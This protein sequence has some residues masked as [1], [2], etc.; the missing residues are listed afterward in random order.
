MDGSACKLLADDDN[1]DWRS[2]SGDPH[3]DEDEKPPNA[4]VAD[5]D[6][7]ADAVR[8]GSAVNPEPAPSRDSPSASSSRSMRPLRLLS[9][10][11]SCRSLLMASSPE[12]AS[13]SCEKPRNWASRRNS[14]CRACKLADHSG[15]D[16]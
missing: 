1:A 14:S 10:S 16:H 5:D 7:A 12:A 4:L 8:K 6:V 2:G 13:S 15:S 11:P 3:S 9:R